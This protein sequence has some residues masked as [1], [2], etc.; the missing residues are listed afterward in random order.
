MLEYFEEDQRSFE[1][2][3]EILFFHI[4]QEANKCVDLQS[5]ITEDDEAR[6]S[7]IDPSIRNAC[8]DQSLKTM[9]ETCVRCLVEE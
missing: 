9:M 4:Y 3:W 5:S 6:R 1:A 2:S 8:L 7:I